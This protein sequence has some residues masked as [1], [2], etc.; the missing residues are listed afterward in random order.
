MK[1]C[2]RCGI[3]KPIAK[4]NR[5]RTR[6]DGRSYVCAEC[7]R[8]VCRGSKR[9]HRQRVA[10]YGAR[11][12]AANRPKRLAH[13]AVARALYSGSLTKMPCEI[14]SDKE[15][16][17]HHDSYEEDRELSVNWLCREHHMARHEEQNAAGLD[18]IVN[19][20]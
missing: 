5:D 20:G 9:K 14:C 17:A 18:S 8:D 1:K 19:S 15:S 2:N 3:A 10:D 13:Q 7:S 12:R 16:E 6:S 4:F 11:Y